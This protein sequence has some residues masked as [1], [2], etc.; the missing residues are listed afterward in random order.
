MLLIDGRYAQSVTYYRKQLKLATELAAA[1]PRN[2]LFRMNVAGSRA[3]LGHALWRAGLVTEGVNTLRHGLAD[4]ADSGQEDSKA[5]GLEMT[6]RGWLAGGLE[7]NGNFDEALHNYLLVHDSQSAICESDPSD[8]E[9]CLGLAG[10]QD[11]IARIYLHRGNFEGALAEYQQA[12]AISEPSIA[13]PKP[14]L[15]ALYTIVNIYYGMGAAYAALA[16]RSAKHS[17]QETNSF[18]KQA[19]TW[20]QKSNAANLRIPDWRPITPNEF[21]ARDL[22]DISTRLLSCHKTEQPTAP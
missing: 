14:N 5:K 10:T 2:M 6:L 7:K 12:L 20:Y 22:K 1:D 19:C 17:A 3:T 11:R 8:L 9:D 18:S 21:D 13:G 15:E 16:N 4:L